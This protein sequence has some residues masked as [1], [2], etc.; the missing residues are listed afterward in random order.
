MQ[1]S[2]IDLSSAFAR[3]LRPQELGIFSRAP[4]DVKELRSRLAAANPV[5]VALSAFLGVLLVVLLLF[6][7]AAALG[8]AKMS[9]T[10]GYKGVVSAPLIQAAKPFDAEAGFVS[11]L[12]TAA[13]WAPD[14]QLVKAQATLDGE[15]GL[16]LDEVAWS[17]L[18]YSARRKATALVV[19]GP[20]RTDLLNTR[21]AT[22]AVALVEPSAWQMDS[23]EAL[24]TFLARGGNLFLD[25]YPQATLTLT[26]AASGGV[27]WQGRLVDDDSGNTFHLSFDAATGALILEPTR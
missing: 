10:E 8:R 9:A 11:A 20:G 12:A 17:Y 26:L 23:A 14:A 13:N 6:V 25:A 24:K 5:A 27:S 22:G 15:S 4:E 2:R 21:P 16:Q 19:A 7:A 3:L 1:L 18:F